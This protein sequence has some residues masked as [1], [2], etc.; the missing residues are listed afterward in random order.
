MLNASLPH[1]YYNIFE[2]NDTPV[3]AYDDGG[4]ERAPDVTVRLLHGNRSVD[5]V[6]AYLNDGR[7]HDYVASYDK[8]TNRL[9]LEDTDDADTVL[10]VKAGTTCQ[11][12]LGLR[13][14]DRATL[15][16]NFHFRLTACSVVD[17]TRTSSAFVHNNLLTQNMDP[18]TRWI[19][20][21]LAKIRPA[22]SSTK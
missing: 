1:S 9:P 15:S 3:L 10:V 7:L 17:L 8:S 16:D 11:R 20:D 14:G 6:V 22:R 5:D 19:G 2:E 18:R 4:Q 12:L 13:V 21:I